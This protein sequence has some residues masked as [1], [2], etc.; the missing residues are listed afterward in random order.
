MLIQSG[1]ELCS[2]WLV[3]GTEYQLRVSLTASAI[4]ESEASP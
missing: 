2:E 4:A 3:F 1:D